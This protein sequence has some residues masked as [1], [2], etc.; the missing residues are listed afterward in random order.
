MAEAFD[1]TVDVPGVPHHDSEVAE[2]A[3]LEGHPD[4][5]LVTVPGLGQFQ[6]GTVNEISAEQIM[7]A[8]STFPAVYAVGDFH[9]PLGVKLEEQKASPSPKKEDKSESKAETKKPAPKQDDKKKE[10]E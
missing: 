1:L 3:V 10:G 5:S 2:N 6:N 7:L 8:G 9:L 4:P